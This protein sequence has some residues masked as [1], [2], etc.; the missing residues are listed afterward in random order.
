MRSFGALLRG[1]FRIPRR[2]PRGADAARV[3]PLPAAETTRAVHRGSR[4]ADGHAARRHGGLERASTLPLSHEGSEM[5]SAGLNCGAGPAPGARRRAT[6]LVTFV[7]PGSF[8]HAGY[9][10]T[11]R[12]G[13]AGSEP[14]DVPAPG[15]RSCFGHRG[16]VL[17]AGED[18]RPG[19]CARQRF[20]CDLFDDK[21]TRECVVRI[22]RKG[23]VSG[24]IL[25]DTR[26][27]PI[28]YTE[29]PRRISLPAFV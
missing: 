3:G 9:P 8:D 12:F 17:P 1:R 2:Q 20:A 22:R 6:A 21:V 25:G 15:D 28:Y 18:V 5:G 10:R 26:Y 19:E 13:V 11:M 29:T 4:A 27:L 24:P 23:P 14:G 7:T 16:R